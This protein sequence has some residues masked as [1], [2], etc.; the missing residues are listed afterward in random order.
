D[1]EAE[2][3]YA[4]ARALAEDTRSVPALSQVLYG[5]ALMCE[6]RGE[7]ERSEQI[8]EER[9][10][11]DSASPMSRIESH[12]LMTCS[13]LHQGRYREAAVHGREALALA[14][15][16]PAEGERLLLLVQAHGWVAG[17][18]F[19]LDEGDAALAH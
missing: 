11:L 15:G 8:L 4:R 6:F 3:N 17:S 16:E 1:P 9:L 18:L 12:E 14:A 10:V 2:A 7:F 19:F 5:M 13:L